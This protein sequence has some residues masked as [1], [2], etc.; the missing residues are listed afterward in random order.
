[1][2]LYGFSCGSIDSDSEERRI[3]YIDF[4][5]SYMTFKILALVL[6]TEFY[7]FILQDFAK[8]IG[9]ECVEL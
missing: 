7:G 1:M 2:V 9:R 4:S 8:I 5:N 3:S 6:I